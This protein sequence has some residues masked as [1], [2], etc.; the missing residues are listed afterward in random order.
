MKID[1]P[2][3]DLL[4][5]VAVTLVT[6]A[7][8]FKFLGLARDY[9]GFWGV[10][11][12]AIFFV[13]TSLVLTQSMDYQEGA[14]YIPFLIRRCFRIYPLA[15]VVLTPVV[16]FRIPQLFSDESGHFTSWNYKPHDIVANF[17]L[18]QDLLY[19]LPAY[20]RQAFPMITS[21]VG[22]MW[23]LSVEMLMYLV[24]PLLFLLVN[25]E[26]YRTV[27]LAGMY[28][29]VVILSIA[30][31]RQF[32]LVEF[33]S[34][35]PVFAAGIISYYLLRKHKFIV[36]AFCWPIF[37]IVVSF[38]LPVSRIPSLCWGL[39]VAIAI[40]WFAQITFRP[41]AVASKLI[42]R[43]SYG[44]YL[45]HCLCMWIAL[46]KMPG[47]TPLRLAAFIILLA[48]VSI[49]LYHGV[50]EPLIQIGKRIAAKYNEIRNGSLHRELSAAD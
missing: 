21:I 10:L 1:Y 40:P 24:L 22:P 31:V 34:Y 29:M 45:T 8:V 16:L 19:T 7:H 36:P 6:A 20:S 12:V 4:R 14:L 27:R 17:L 38:V 5:A 43:Y 30:G 3:L 44:I 46:E 11:G 26:R 49:G 47:P 48:A 23:S 42:A 41:L 25:R 39:L 37:V 18:V 2:N 9:F 35:A 50:E 28:L 15:I 13:H 32:P 33:F